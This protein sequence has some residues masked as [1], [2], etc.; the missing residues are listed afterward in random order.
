[1]GGGARVPPPLP[2]SGRGEAVEEQ[3][4]SVVRWR[5]DLERRSSSG[6][7]RV[8]AQVGRAALGWLGLT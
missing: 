4:R 5:G 1:M 8:G 7:D 3:E 6:M 2:S